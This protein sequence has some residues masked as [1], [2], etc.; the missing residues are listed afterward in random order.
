MKMFGIGSSRSTM[1]KTGTFAFSGWMLWLL[2]QKSQKLFHELMG[3]LEVSVDRGESNIGNPI[4]DLQFLHDQLS[5][6]P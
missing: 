1:R 6:D 5:Y 3:V 4:E 2:P